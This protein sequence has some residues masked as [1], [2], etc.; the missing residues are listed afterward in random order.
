[1]ASLGTFARGI[2]RL[3]WAA[4]LFLSLP[5]RPAAAGAPAPVTS[6]E[7]EIK[8]AALYNII[9]FTG[10]P[11]EA[12]SSP[13]AP[14]VIGVLG[15]GPVEAL[16]GRMVDNETWHGRRIVLEHYARA[17]DIKRCHVLFI[18]QSE[19]ARWTTVRGVVSGRPVL[20]VCDLE[21]FV[22]QGGIVQ[23]TVERNKLRLRVNLGAARQ[24]NLRISSNVLRLAE[25]VGDAG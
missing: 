1:M 11:A 14:L 13:E 19:Q 9:A 7:A 18:A 12:F 23:F 5:G 21:N 3:T 20:T 22:R 15:V 6:R 4:G 8:A 16:L 24:S 17:S 2:F 10:W 25:I